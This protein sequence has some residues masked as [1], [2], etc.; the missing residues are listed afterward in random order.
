MTA[1]RESH[2]TLRKTGIRALLGRCRIL[3]VITV[4]D[5]DQAV[6]LV[7]ALAEGGLSTVEITL[8]TEAA[9]S[10]IEAVVERLDG[11]TVGA[12]T[13]TSHE[14]LRHAADAGAAF[15]VSPGATGELLVAARA[16]EVPFLPGVATASEAM[17]ARDVG[18]D[19][20]KLFP[21]ASLGGP[22]F[23]ASLRG[24]LPELFFCPTG[25]IRAD[26]YS[27]YL[28]QPNVVCVGGSWMVPAAAV[29]AEDW[30]TITREARRFAP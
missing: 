16:W 11:V 10:A 26:T 30:P 23:L 2:Q 19:V 9:L 7:G 25:G 21:A 8:R 3:P 28:E 17:T 5:A 29:A 6:A 13:V 1:M 14:Q 12:G 27:Q 22:S 20:L 24:P 18:F 4:E 15:A